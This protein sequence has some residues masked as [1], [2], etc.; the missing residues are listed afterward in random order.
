MTEL[1]RIIEMRH[2]LQKRKEFLLSHTRHQQPDTQCI[3]KL[4]TPDC[5]LMREIELINQL[6]AHLQSEIFHISEGHEV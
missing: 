3:I 4:E 5:V 2:M 6:S 1:D